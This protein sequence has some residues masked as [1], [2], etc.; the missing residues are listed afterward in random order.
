VLLRGLGRS[1]GHWGE[2]PAR[3][4]A[5]FPGTAVL[6]PDLPGTGERRE[7]AA[8]ATVGETLAAVRAGLPSGGPVSVLGLSLG[9]MVAFEWARRH[10]QELAR[11][12]L[13]NTSLGGLV[14]PWRRLR[15][16]AALRLVG[17][18]ATADPVT[19][20]RRILALNSNRT[21]LADEMVP[22][23]AALARAQPV[24]RIE[25]LRQLR[26]A[27]RYR[28]P[29]SAPGVRLLLLASRADRMVDPACSRALAAAIPGATLDQHP[30]AGHDVPLDDP[31]WVVAR[32]AG[33]HTP[34][35]L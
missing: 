27:A 30:T 22:R 25:V 16:S 18:I 20:E 35:A 23:W 7:L 13:V 33:W 29:L 3:L 21:D 5:A 6:T 17:L 26:A 8:P 28:P 10:P 15:P 12:V 2:F 4:R 34:T 14:P 1:Q 24:R 31:E 11:A 19:R 32:I 9:G